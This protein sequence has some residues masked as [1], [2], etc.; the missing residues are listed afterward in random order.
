MTLVQDPTDAAFPDMPLNALRRMTPDYVLPMADI[1]R[2]LVDLAQRPAGKPVPVPAT[3]PFEVEIARGETRDPQAQMEDMDRIGRR[4]LLAC[5]ECHGVMWEIKEGELTRYRCHT[6]HAYTA[7]LL[8]LALEE[9]LRRALAGAERALEE[10]LTLTRNLHRQAE[11]AQHRASA[12]NWAS[13]V[14]E[15][16]EELA[17]LRSA[18]RR[19]EELKAAIVRDEAEEPNGPTSAR[20]AAEE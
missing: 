16:Q 4:S 14:T 6:G 11:E 3:V 8:S 19:V 18:M 15:V 10:R 20:S 12:A 5:P 9:S 7:E 1:A 17:T 13:R 2:K